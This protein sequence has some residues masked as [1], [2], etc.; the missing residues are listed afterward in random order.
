MKALLAAAAA[1]L[2]LLLASPGASRAQ[3]AP[4]DLP[5]FIDAYAAE[6]DFNGVIRV[7]AKG[8]AI[9]ARAFGLADRAFA[10]PVT[11]DTRFRIASITKLFAAVLVLQ[12]QEEGRLNV[13]DLVGRHLP[14]LPGEAGGRVTLR[15]LLNHTSGLA[16]L[17]TVGSYQEAFADG[18]PHYQRPM[19]SAA[20][21]AG[22][23]TGALVAEPGTVFAYNNADYILLAAVIERV[24][25]QGWEAVLRDRILSPLGL[26]DT[27]VAHWD[28]ITERLAPTYLHRDDTGTLIA[29]MP[30]YYENWSAAGA[31]YS[32]ARDLAVFADALYGGRLLKPESLE[33]LLAPG[34]D[35]YGFGLWSYSINRGGQTWHVAKRPGSVMGANGVVYRLREADLTI[36][37]LSNTNLT[38]LDVFAQRIANRWIDN[39]AREE[40]V[41]AR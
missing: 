35:D 21:V 18:M 28:A 11:G 16:P 14:D 33:P 22:C 1:C 39:H 4:A 23:C 15:Q 10:V 41:T 37:L 26:A 36:V 38:D 9:H 32:T 2:L 40:A 12:L 8:E 20:L 13:D 6:H 7:E 5:G 24:T 25:G 31:M 19:T 30:V 27:G 34:L 17:D 3:E 29:D